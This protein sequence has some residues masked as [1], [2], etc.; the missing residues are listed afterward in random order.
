MRTFLRIAA[1]FILTLSVG[2]AL[3]R[4]AA[5]AEYGKG[6]LEG[7]ASLDPDGGS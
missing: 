3:A 4:P 2:L 5:A 6:L 7:A 1:L